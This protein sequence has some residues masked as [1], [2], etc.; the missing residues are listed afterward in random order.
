MIF[1]D[2][3]GLRDVAPNTCHCFAMILAQS[4][5]LSFDLLLPLRFNIAHPKRDHPKKE[6]IVFQLIFQGASCSFSGV[7]TVDG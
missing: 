1:H 6:R 5:G 4:V 3:V 2:V 7:H